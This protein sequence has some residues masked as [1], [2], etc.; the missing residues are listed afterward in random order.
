MEKYYITKDVYS[1]CF[2]TLLCTKMP[3]CMESTLYGETKRYF[4]KYV[5]F[6]FSVYWHVRHQNAKKQGKLPVRENN[7]P[8]KMCLLRYFELVTYQTVKC[9]QNTFFMEK[10]NNITKNKYFDGFWACCVQKRQNGC[11]VTFIR[12]L[13]EIMWNV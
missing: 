6:V 1:Q 13:K 10:Q 5:F 9:T 11:K 4:L 3:K 8:P 12:K 2:F 7:S